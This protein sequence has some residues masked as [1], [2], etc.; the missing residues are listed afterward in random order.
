MVIRFLL[1][2]FVLAFPIITLAFS[3][4]P[5]SHKNAEAIDYI[6]EEEIIS[7]FS[8]G[9]F[10]PEKQ[11]SRAAFTKIVVLASTPE[12]EI[13]NCTQTYARPQMSI[14]FFSDVKKDDWFAPYACVAGTNDIIGGYADNTF[15]PANTINLAA[16]AKIIT[17]AFGIPTEE[18][19]H[20][21]L[22]YLP[23]ISA[24]QELEVVEKNADPWQKVTRAETAEMLFRVL[25]IEETE[26]DISQE[27]LLS[28]H[29]KI[30]EKNTTTK[31]TEKEETPKD[32]CQISDTFWGECL[33]G[34]VFDAN[35]GRCIRKCE[36]DGCAGLDEIIFK[37]MEKISEVPMVT[38]DA[39]QSEAPVMISTYTIKNGSIQISEL[40]KDLDPYL[41]KIQKNSSVHKDIWK[42]VQQI[43]P[44]KYLEPFAE[45]QI[46]SDG[47]GEMTGEV[48]RQKKDGGFS[49]KWV[50]AFDPKDN[51]DLAYS[52]LHELGHAIII[53][54]EKME[55]DA[56]FYA[57]QD[58]V[59]QKRSSARKEYLTA[60]KEQF[61]EPYGDD[62]WR[63]GNIEDDAKKEREIQI[64]SKKYVD[65]FLTEYSLTNPTEDFCETFA[66]FVLM[67]K[68]NSDDAVADQK[69]L[70]FYDYPELVRLRDSL[71][72]SL[73]LEF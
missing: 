13:Q 21:S 45:F 57:C 52:I 51:D 71:R 37:K 50:L 16:A 8:D 12:S 44:K 22:W 49:G 63:I 68:P 66:H 73:F 34:E 3:D 10:Q 33:K 48:Y 56:Q 43:F 5:D 69:I 9:T 7:G 11:I 41:Q 65:F 19:L 46:F 28:I 55:Y 72:W 47:A 29:K 20:E 39:F 53:T 1:A 35:L 42:K 62:F 17:K 36:T 67:E 32:P 6:A 26:S 18:P 15:R 14:V 27:S 64:L 4:V 23:G 31:K 58:E 70:F 25:S 2:F 30:Q 40:G 38:N 61:W 54:D 60:Y 24:L 59:I